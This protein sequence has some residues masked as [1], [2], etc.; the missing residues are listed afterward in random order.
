MVRFVA[1]APVGHSSY[2]RCMRFEAT[3]DIA[4]R[5]EHVFA[6]YTDVEQ[7]PDWTRSVTSVERLDQDRCGRV[8]APG[9]G[10]PASRWRYGR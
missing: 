7:W 5:V 9:S 1:T 4:A 3:I 6:V 10:N 8:P 2:C